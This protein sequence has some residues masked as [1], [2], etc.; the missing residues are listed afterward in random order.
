M[1]IIIINGPN[2]NLLGKRQPEI[3]G[4]T[5]FEDYFKTLQSKF[6]DIDLEY[7]QSNH[8]GTLIDKIQ[9]VGFSYDGIVIN[10]GGYSHTSVAIADSIASIKANVIEVHITNISAREDYRKISYISQHCEAVISGLGL[11]GYEYAVKGLI[12]SLNKK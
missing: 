1:K 8:E 2:L 3:Y 5:K 11:D 10:A 6:S 12:E 7:F 4:H 9:E